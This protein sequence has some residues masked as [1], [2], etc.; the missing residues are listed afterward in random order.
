V[1]CGWDW[2]KA[3]VE[4]DPHI[5]LSKQMLISSY[6][7]PYVINDFINKQLEIA[8]LQFEFEFEGKFHYLIFKYKKIIIE[9]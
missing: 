3:L 9:I 8:N 6:S 2:E 4:L 1:A 5:I 7:K